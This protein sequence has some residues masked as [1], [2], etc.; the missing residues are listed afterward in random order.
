L[1]GVSA[2]APA[3]RHLALALIA[4]VL[5]VAL[6]A[7]AGC[8]SS[9]ETTE[10][11]SSSET[12]PPAASQSTSKA[13]I[14]AS[15]KSCSGAVVSKGPIRVVGTSCGDGAATARAWSGSRSCTGPSTAS[16][17]ACSVEGYRCLS[18]RTER[19]IE[20]NCAR[21]GRSVSFRIE[22]AA[23]APSGQ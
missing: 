14:G 20:V 4:A 10:S 16:R 19:A 6:I 18:V 5:P 8:G 22:G 7:L 13:P 17:S 12:K 1:V 9:G 15:A 3:R 2:S 23:P 21:P 11:R